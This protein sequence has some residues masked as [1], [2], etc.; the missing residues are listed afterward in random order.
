MIV[1]GEL[2]DQRKE[3]T[4]IWTDGGLIVPGRFFLSNSKKT[5]LS[6]GGVSGTKQI[7]SIYALL[8]V[9]W[10][11]QLFV[12]VTGRNDWSSALVY[13]N[14][15]GNYSYFYPSV[16]TSWI[17]SETFDLPDWFT[18][19]KTRLSWAQVGNDTSPY[20]INNGYSIG[21]YEMAGGSFIYTNS[22]ST[23]LVDPSIKPE[24][25]NSFEGGLDLRFFNNRAG[26]DFTVYSETINNQ[27]GAI[28]VPGESGYSSM[29]SNIGSLTNKGLELSVRLV[30]VKTR[31]LEWETTFNYWNNTTMISNLRPE[32]GEY[33]TLGGD[34]AYGN[35]RVGSVAYEDGEYGILMSDTKPLEW[36]NT[37]DANDPRNGMKVLTWNNTRRGAYYTRS[38]K[39]EEVGKIQPDFEGSWNNQLTYKN[40]SLTVLL[41]ARF[42]GNIASYSNK[43]GT[44]YGYLETSLAGRDA[45]YGGLP[46][47]TNYADSKGQSFVDGVIPDGVF[48]AGQKV[49]APNGQSVDVGGLTYK[50]AM[51]KGYVEPTHASY[52]TYRNNSWSSGVI[53]DDWFSEVNYIA[54]RN[55]SVS[56]NLPTSFARKIKATSL[57]VAIN[58]RNLGYLYNS[59]PNHLNPESFRGT[60]STESFRERSFSPYTASYTMTLSVGF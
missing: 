56:Y 57:S 59:L 11:N 51:D 40:L 7:N 15:T 30:P 38:N 2:W 21:N 50:E 53:N 49:T 31:N 29:I 32:V 10:K 28:P 42:G 52:F 46:W 26:I 17:F 34:I 54:L 45:E 44:A 19:G 13:T 55:I 41:D 37:A 22:K 1:G 3:N 23:I 47:T 35:F 39:A 4:R 14:G 18:L 25:K 33:K 36:N 20:Y 6:E 58:A 43:Y 5:L 24:R 27:I 16:S 12:D 9:G 60:S 8:N 48:A